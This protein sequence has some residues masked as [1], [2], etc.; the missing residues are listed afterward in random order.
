MIAHVPCFTP[1]AERDPASAGEKAA[2]KASVAG[3]ARVD[4]EKAAQQQQIKLQEQMERILTSVK[5]T[6]EKEQGKR[7]AHSQRKPEV[8]TSNGT[9]PELQAHMGS[10]QTKLNKGT[11]EVHLCQVVNTQKPTGCCVNDKIFSFEFPQIKMEKIFLGRRSPVDQV[12]I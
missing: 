12:R 4:L 2:H 8:T 11:G 7:S 5:A 9:A 1:S 6:H 3:G 10:A